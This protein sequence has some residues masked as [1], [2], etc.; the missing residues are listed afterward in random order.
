M[1]GR[2]RGGKTAPT[3]RKKPPAFKT[4]FCCNETKLIEAFH[5]HKTMSDGHLNKCKP[6]CQ[7]NIRANRINKYGSMKEYRKYS[8]AKELERGTRSRLAPQKYGKDPE[9]RK[10]IVAK[11]GHKRRTKT[12][13]VTEFDEFVFA[14]AIRL[15][16]MRKK[17]TGI[18]WSL[19]HVIPFEH[20]DA[21]GLHNAYNFQVVPLLWNSI[22]GHRTM[23]TFFPD[24]RQSSGM[25]M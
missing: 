4:C 10:I 19:D 15:C 23:E 5:F 20:K 13:L 25:G 2:N 7:A 1:T 16:T 9:S 21:C 17:A 24:G 8:Y 18:R 14:E 3:D 11:Y 12:K 6:C 22:K